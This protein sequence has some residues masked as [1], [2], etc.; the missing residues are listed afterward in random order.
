MLR[1]APLGSA[2]VSLKHINTIPHDQMV[3]DICGRTLLRGEHAESFVNGNMRRQVCQL[4]ISRALH[5]G[6]VREGAL[7]ALESGSSGSERRRSIFGRLRSRRDTNDSTP[8]PDE[9]LSAN[10]RPQNDL[11]ST[12]ARGRSRESRHVRAVPASGEQKMVSAVGLFNAS[13]HRRTV[14]GVAR[15]LGRPVVNVAPEEQHPSL[16][17]IVVSWELCWYRYEVDISDEVAGVRL[18]N[19]GYELTDLS[20]PERHPNASADD[21]GQLSVS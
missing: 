10:T 2:G 8:A 19:Q 11:N 5:E 4:C 13:E 1:L 12:L 20:A 21:V 15:S 3:C 6:W 16:V 17:R 14:S 9:D 18:V 7:Q